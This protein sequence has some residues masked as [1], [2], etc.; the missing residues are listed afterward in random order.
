M[1]HGA[2]LQ[3]TLTGSYD[4]QVSPSPQTRRVDLPLC[5]AAALMVQQG[6]RE[7]M[8]CHTVELRHAHV[9]TWGWWGIPDHRWH[10]LIGHR[11]MPRLMMFPLAPDVV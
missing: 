3:K 1:R 8:S 2:G 9:I 10:R 11:L 4:T 7:E 6:A 5:M